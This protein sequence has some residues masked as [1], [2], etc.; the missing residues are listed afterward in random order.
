MEM[1]T[2]LMAFGTLLA[3]WGIRRSLAVITL[4]ASSKSPVSV[5]VGATLALVVV[6]VWCCIWTRRGSVSSRDKP[7][8]DCWDSIYCNRR[9][10]VAQP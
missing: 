9:V 2:M 4:C 7:T 5:F 3:K 1:K 10:D 6:T 8:S